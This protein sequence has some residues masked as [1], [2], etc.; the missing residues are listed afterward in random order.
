MRPRKTTMLL[1]SLLIA[2]L[3]AAAAAED[4][5]ALPDHAWLS[6]DGEVRSVTSDAFVLDYGEDTI[7]VEMDDGDRDADGYKLVAGD[8]VTVTGAIDDDVFESRTIE[9]ASV[10]VE[11][12]GTTFYAS[13]AD[14]EDHVFP[15]YAPVHVGRTV[16]Q[17]TVTEVEDEEFLLA[18]GGR[19]LRIEVEEMN[20]DPLDD[21]GYQKIEV[22]DEVSV[23]GQMDYDFLEGREFVA[24]S[25]VT[26]AK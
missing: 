10:H 7:T 2:L 1:S 6:L 5:Y 19:E 26:L 17:G 4:P 25:V 13:A 22:G 20:Y 23:A 11:K 9:A 15:T 14:E 3:A 21:E 24:S 8:R 16:L 18:T 12:L